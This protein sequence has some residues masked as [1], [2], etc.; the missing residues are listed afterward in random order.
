[1][2]M[3]NLSVTTFRPYRS[4]LWSQLK[5]HF[6]EWWCRARSRREL[7][8][9]GDHELWDLGMSCS[10]AEFEASKPWWRE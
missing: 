8:T 6:A 10:T 7:M 4:S 5:H 9:L 3:I 1:M 2:S